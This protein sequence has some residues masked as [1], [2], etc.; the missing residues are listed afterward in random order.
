MIIYTG[1][2]NLMKEI[3]SVQWI[4]NDNKLMQFFP[5]QCKPHSV[6]KLILDITSFYAFTITV[7]SIVRRADG[8]KVDTASLS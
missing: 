5:I 4:S 3:I 8:L 7:T 2:K 1:N 6:N